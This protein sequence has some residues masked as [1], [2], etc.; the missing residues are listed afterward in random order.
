MVQVGDIITAFGKPWVVVGNPK[1]GVRV[2]PLTRKTGKVG[3]SV[4]VTKAKL[5]DTTVKLG[6]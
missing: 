3:K 2:R 5:K 4:L 1:A 6:Y